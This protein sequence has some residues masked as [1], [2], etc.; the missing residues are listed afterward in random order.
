M[1]GFLMCAW[2]SDSSSTMELIPPQM[3]S[4]SPDT[5]DSFTH[6]TGVRSRSIFS[7]P[8]DPS[9]LYIWN[10]LCGISNIFSYTSFSKLNS[11]LQRLL[12]RIPCRGAVRRSAESMLS[13]TS[14][15]NTVHIFTNCCVIG[16]VLK[17]KRKSP[18]LQHA[19]EKTTRSETGPL[20]N[21]EEEEQAVHSGWYAW[22]NLCAT[23]IECTERLP[24]CPSAQTSHTNHQ[25]AM[26]PFTGWG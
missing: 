2:I 25:L 11:Q 6:E 26:T 21:E 1:C 20:K 17:R 19:D 7:F 23:I 24:G 18:P 3:D 9:F 13:K 8:P 10:S 22:C 12:L 15:V 16:F 14:W 4:T 5:G